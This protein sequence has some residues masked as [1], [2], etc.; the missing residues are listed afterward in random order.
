MR[1]NIE[2]TLF[3]ERESQKGIVIGKG[4]EMLKRIGTWARRE[5][6]ALTGRKVFLQLRVKVL[7][8]WR[9]DEQMLKRF[10][11]RPGRF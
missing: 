2:A 5:I 4:G 3:V 1:R 11:F 10:G 7:P 9:N 6:E 8:G